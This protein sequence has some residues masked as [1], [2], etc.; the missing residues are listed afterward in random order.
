MLSLESKNSHR[1]ERLQFATEK[2]R[3][4]RHV[5][6]RGFVS[7]EHQ[8]SPTPKEDMSAMIHDEPGMEWS[9]SAL[10]TNF[11]SLELITHHSDPFC[12]IQ[13][14]F[15]PEMVLKQPGKRAHS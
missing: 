5:V 2:W 1:F 9:L 10:L 11:P 7:Q 8:Q 13:Q 15:R 12:T 3:V 14:G 4:S 6:L